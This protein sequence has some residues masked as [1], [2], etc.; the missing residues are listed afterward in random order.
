MYFKHN[1]KK[2]FDITDDNAKIPGDINAITGIGNSTKGEAQNKIG[3]FGVGFKAV[4][5]YTDV[6]EIYDDVFKFKIEEHI[7]PKLLDEDHPERKDG[8][9]LFVFPF[10]NPE[11]AYAD[12]VKRVETLKS[13]ILF[14]A[15]L[16][17]IRIELDDNNKKTYVDEYSKKRLQTRKYKDGIFLNKYLLTSPKSSNEVLI[18]GKNIEVESGNETTNHTIYVAFYYDSTKKEIITGSK[19]N[20]FCFFST[21]LKY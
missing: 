9:T 17:N 7:V 13:P 4:F 5:Q 19:Q 12:I 10:K 8:E 2:H 3:K 20:V 21:T 15:N 6:P 1:G 16:E 11:K 18:Y 14:L